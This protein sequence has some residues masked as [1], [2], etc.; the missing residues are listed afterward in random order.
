MSEDVRLW[1]LGYNKSET[2]TIQ[3]QKQKGQPKSSSSMRAQQHA[4]TIL[5][6]VPPND[7]SDNQRALV[8]AANEHA[9]EQFVNNHSLT[10]P[11]NSSTPLQPHDPRRVLST[12]LS[13]PPNSTS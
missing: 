9:I 3:A 12:K 7:V 2:K 10:T 4:Q 6:P 1:Y 8:L 13:L 5:N 11:D